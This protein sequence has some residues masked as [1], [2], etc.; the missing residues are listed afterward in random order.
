MAV[1]LEVPCDLAKK[2]IEEKIADLRNRKALE[3]SGKTE[4]VITFSNYT[5]QKVSKIII[6]VN[7]KTLP[8]NESIEF[9]GWTKLTY[10]NNVSK[11]PIPDSYTDGFDYLVKGK[12]ILKDK[13]DYIDVFIENNVIEI[14]DIIH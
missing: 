11:E 4:K 14:T 5:L 2:A 8:L 1:K 6:E 3:F 9:I 10:K 12:A 7:R 13:D